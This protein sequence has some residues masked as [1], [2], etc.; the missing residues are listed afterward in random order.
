MKAL[1]TV[2]QSKA[3]VTDPIHRLLQEKTSSVRFEF[4]YDATWDYPI[5]KVP[6]LLNYTWSLTQ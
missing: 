4:V 1:G 2:L 3:P 6:G 5:V